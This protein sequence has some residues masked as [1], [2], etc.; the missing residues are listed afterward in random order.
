MARRTLWLALAL[1]ATQLSTGCCGYFRCLRA[2]ICNPPCC[3]PCSGPV[4][5]YGGPV[6]IG[7]CSSCYTAPP[8]VPGPVI[9]NLPPGIPAG[10]PALPHTSEPLP[11]PKPIAAPRQ[12]H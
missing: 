8:L 5:G 12:L 1:A 10:M 11:A 2:R 3:A 4:V 7:G 6:G 9:S